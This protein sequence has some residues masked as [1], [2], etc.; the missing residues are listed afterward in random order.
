MSTFLYP[1][2][3]PEWAE[4]W[5]PGVPGHPEWGRNYVGVPC[6][7]DGD[8]RYEHDCYELGE[9]VALSLES[10]NEG[11]EHDRVGAL[12]HRSRG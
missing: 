11:Y 10:E 12:W 7:D 2:Q 1:E 6:D 3:W 5:M 8:R 9:N 4:W